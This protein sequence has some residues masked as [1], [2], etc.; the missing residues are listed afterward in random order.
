MLFNTYHFIFGFLP[1]VL[2]FF[3][4]LGSFGATK[5][6]M[7]TLVLASLVYYGWWNPAYVWLIVLSLLI[8]FGIGRKLILGDHSDGNRKLWMLVGVGGNLALLAYYKYA[9][10]FVDN[11]NALT[12]TRFHLEHI[13]LPLAISFFT[14][15]Q[16]AFIVDA[17]QRKAAEPHFL[18]YCLFVTFF[19]QLIAGP[20]VHH[21]EMMPQFLERKRYCFSMREFGIGLTIFFIGLF[22]KVIIADELASYASAAFQ[23]AGSGMTFTFFEA[24]TAAL[25][26]TMQLYFD[27]SGYSDMAV[28]LAW[29]FGVRLPMNFNSPYQARNI[30]DFWRRWHMTLSRFLRDYLYIP[31]GGNRRGPIRRHVNLIATMILG[32]LWHGAGWTYV[33][34]GALHGAYLMI[35]HFWRHHF[36]IATAGVVRAFVY[37]LITF[38][39]VVVSWIFFR[40]S[41]FEAATSILKGMAGVN[42]ISLPEGLAGPL[43]GLGQ[44]THG[45]IYFEGIQVNALPVGVPAALWAM[46]ACLI[47][48]LSPNVYQIMSRV[49]PAFETYQGELNALVRSWIVWRPSIPWAVAICVIGLWALL[50]LS[51]VSEFLYFQF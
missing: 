4:V 16:I 24:W 18:P 30:I 49:R 1:V 20:I 48:F 10:F 22:K 2:I 47:A 3:Y 23:G 43:A 35:N 8:N 6:A 34:W 25:S 13:V 11:L 37:W 38:V 14:F 32:G 12:G 41:S 15:Q 26:Y 51:R 42:G 44:A 31:L 46:A 21:G 27:F 28:G 9:N 29:L 17:Y 39:A 33:A 45:W 7:G 40:A 36:G 50:N 19:P 5:A